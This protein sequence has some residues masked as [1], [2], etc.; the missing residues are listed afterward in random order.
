MDNEIT[1]H[2]KSLRKHNNKEIFENFNCIIIHACVL[3]GGVYINMKSKSVFHNK[4]L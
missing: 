1:T 3:N 4:I 2:Y